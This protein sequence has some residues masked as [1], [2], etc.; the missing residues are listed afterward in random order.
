MIDHLAREAAAGQDT[1]IAVNLS[2]RSLQN[3]VFVTVLRRLMQSEAALRPRLLIEIT[4]TAR[5]E[6]PD[7]LANVLRQLSTDGHLI[8]ID[9]FGAGET[10]F[11]H[12]RRYH[13]D[14]VKI[15][16][17]YIAE[18][19]HDTRS[20]SIVGAIAALCR[21]LGIRTVA[22]MIETDAQAAQ[23]RELGIDLG[24]GYL[25]GRPAPLP[26]GTDL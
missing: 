18:V 23:A 12:L 9:D 6:D 17:S 15:D 22:E 4:E 10:S 3:Q 21:D 1:R 8:C 26:A 19:G 20:A 13:A 5:I 16:G 11:N 24:Q 7:L 14:F 25:F 2:A